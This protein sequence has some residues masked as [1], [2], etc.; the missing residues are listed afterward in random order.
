MHP[1]DAVV[2]R[3]QAAIPV[4]AAVTV[5]LLAVVWAL[6]WVPLPIMLSGS[7][8]PGVAQWLNV[9]ALG[10]GP[11]VLGYLLT[12][13][14]SLIPP[15]R[16]LR[17]GGVAGRVRLNRIALGVSLAVA[18]LQALA[19]AYRFRSLFHLLSPLVKVDLMAPATHAEEA[20]AIVGSL[21]LRNV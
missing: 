11:L 9:G 18:A 6:R 1:D 13:L 7:P 5:A 14:L 16:R 3:P 12:E 20:A 17:Q 19:R 15:G 2:R 10:I 4:A 8:T 21:K